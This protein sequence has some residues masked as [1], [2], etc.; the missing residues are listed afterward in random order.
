MTHKQARIIKGFA[1]L[2]REAFAEDYGITTVEIEL[3]GRRV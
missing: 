1:L 3:V 2:T